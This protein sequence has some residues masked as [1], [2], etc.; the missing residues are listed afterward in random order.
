MQRVPVTV[1]LEPGRS[2]QVEVPAGARGLILSGANVPRLPEGTILGRI[3]PGGRIIRIGDIAD[4]GALRRDHYYNSRNP[5]PRRPGG[6]LR[7]YGQTSWIDASGRIA[8][9]P[10]VVTVTADRA[11]P[12]DARL[13]IDAI[14]LGQ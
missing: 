4:W 12:N 3:D 8:V 5:L 13:Q 7:G 1:A 14:E 9:R 11:L 10:G 6:L 2:A